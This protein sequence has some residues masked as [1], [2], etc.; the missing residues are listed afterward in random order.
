MS[1]FQ[2]PAQPDWADDAFSEGVLLRRVFAWFVD[3][4]L[5][6]I[7][8]AV[9]WMFC[10]FFGVMTFGLGWPLFGL[11]P[12]VPLL[13]QWLFL[14]GPPSATPGQMLLG[15]VVRR[16]D[17]LGPPTPLQALAFTLLFF[18]TLALGVIWMAVALFTVRHRTFHEI[19]SG[20][21][22]IRAR[23]LDPPLTTKPAS[24]NMRAGGPNA[25]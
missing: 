2:A 1:S 16:N 17:D 23:A 11:L 5:Q 4:V 7:I 19:I 25:A 3:A 8:L 13:Y 15:L 24:W 21:V 10:L 18:L 6:A 9:L 14:A 12:L 22:V 20:L